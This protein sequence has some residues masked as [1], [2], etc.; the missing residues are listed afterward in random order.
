MHVEKLEQARL[1]D[2]LGREQITNVKVAQPATLVHKPVSPKKPLV[3]G[4]GLLVALFGGLSL[5]FLAE[6][7]DQTL[8]TTDQVE[9]QLGLPVLASLPYRKRRRKQLA[10]LVIDAPAK[11]VGAK[12]IQ[13]GSSQRDSYRG[14]LT[15]LSANGENGHRRAKTVGVV[16]CDTSKVRSLVAGNIAVQAA[17]AA[18]DPVLLIDGDARRQRIAKRFRLNGAPGW[19]Q[20]MAG[21]AVAEKCVQWSK[22]SNLAVMGPGN[23][24]GDAPATDSTPNTLGD[25]NGITT[26]FGLVIVDLPSTRE[27]QGS[28][29]A[30]EWIDEMVLVVDAER[31]R[32]QAARRTIDVLRRAGIRVTG[33][34]LANRR[35]HIPRWLYQRL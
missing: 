30:P 12:S 24:N 33:V 34:V 5:A 8:R 10:G 17:N 7:V 18:A 29:A 23:A 27:Q 22:P 1:N 20:L 13:H 19:R 35:E 21:S 26:G 25:L 4:L 3:L 15:A 16:G 14:L 11:T 2:A 28:S 9:M 31:T 6:I 32:I